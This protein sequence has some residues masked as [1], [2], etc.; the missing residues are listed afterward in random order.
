MKSLNYYLPLLDSIP[1]RQK[2]EIKIIVGAIVIRSGDRAESVAL[3]STSLS[4]VQKSFGASRR[5]FISLAVSKFS[6]F[7]RW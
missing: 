3:Q 1:I 6:F 5:D 2:K 7:R 4:I